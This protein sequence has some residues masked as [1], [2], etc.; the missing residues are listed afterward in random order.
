MLQRILLAT[1]V[2][3]ILGISDRIKIAVN[4]PLQSSSH[5]ADLNRGPTHYE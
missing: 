3:G 2:A 4:M 1:A 5:L